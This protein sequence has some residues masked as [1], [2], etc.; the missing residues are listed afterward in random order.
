MNIGR[1]IPLLREKVAIFWGINDLKKK[2]SSTVKGW[3]KWLENERRPS[4][5]SLR[6]ICDEFGLQM[7]D[8]EKE[9]SLQEFA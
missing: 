2:M 8:F 3:K 7:S 9:V 6:T 1:E 5:D 4:E